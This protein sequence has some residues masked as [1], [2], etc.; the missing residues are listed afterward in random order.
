[1]E[2]EIK[3][4]PLYKQIQQFFLDNIQQGNWKPEEKIPSENELSK[5]FNVSRI[6]IKKA[7]DEL[8]ESGLVYR[9]QGKGTFLASDYGSEPVIY[10]HKSVSAEQKNKL[11]AVMMPRVNTLFNAA[12]LNQ[13]E[14]TLASDGYRM[15]VCQTKDSQHV[16]EQSIKAV[17]EIGVQGII[18]Y[19]AEG[20][21]Y[22]EEVLRLTLE[23]F[24][25]VLIDRYFR[26]IDANSV[27]SDNIDGAYQAT[28]YLLGL[29][30]SRIGIISSKHQGTT[31]I[32][33]RI[34]G[35]EKALADFDIPIDHRLYN[36]NLEIMNRAEN[37]AK[38]QEF[39]KANHDLTAIFAISNGLDVLKAAKI[40]EIDIPND[41]SV[42]MF[43]DH[44]YAQFFNQAPTCI[45]QD[46]RAI[47]ESAANLVISSI[48]NPTIKRQKI[49]IP[50]KLIVRETTI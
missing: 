16:E 7:L 27:C 42:I 44:D 39:L 24:P 6:T 46:E 33:D 19:P 2:F 26:G 25:I 43:D 13:I 8:V 36:L 49:L 50:T 48:K 47:G 10:E 35:H 34:A 38:I 37:V 40:S 14:Q 23:G 9:I 21:T 11:I 17:L 1:M 18:I 30:H 28:K 41:L 29:G 4:V 3:R 31:S 45:K 20:E 5:Q 32:E 12:I 15:I 22:N